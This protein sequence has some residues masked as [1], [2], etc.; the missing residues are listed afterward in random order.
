MHD[1]HTAHRGSDRGAVSVEADGVR[2]RRLGDDPGVDERDLS[3]GGLVAGLVVL[4]VS[5]GVAGWVA[6]RMAR[7]DGVRNGVLTAVLFLVLAAAMSALGAWAGE[8]YDFFDEVQLPQWFTELGSGAAIASAIAGVVVMLVAAAIG[9]AIGARYH[10]RADALITHTRDGGIVR[11]TN[12]EATV[13]ST[14]ATR[15]V[16]R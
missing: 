5:F 11:A 3:I 8:E 7:Y 15:R 1:D 9:G 6:G 16:R 13:V 12:A 14:D 4:L 10:R 2:H